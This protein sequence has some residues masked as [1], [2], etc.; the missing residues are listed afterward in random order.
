MMSGLVRT[1]SES[2][3]ANS[4]GQST[5]GGT[6]VKKL[7]LFGFMLA[8]APC[9][10]GGDDDKDNG[11]NGSGG[12][13]ETQGTGGSEDTEGTGGTGGTGTKEPVQCGGFTCSSNPGSESCNMSGCADGNTYGF[14]CERSV[15]N[16]GW[17]LH[18]ECSMGE[19]AWADRIPTGVSFDLEVDWDWDDSHIAPMARDLL[20]ERCGFGPLET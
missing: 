6:A 16:T 7:V 1:T 5:V 14:R 8:L 19:G 11:N 3:E 4:L 13:G 17:S 20:N 18:C 2:A 12:E 15:A 10:C 9:A